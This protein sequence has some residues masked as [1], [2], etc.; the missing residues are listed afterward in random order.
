MRTLRFF[1]Y[2]TCLV[3]IIWSGVIL[4]GPS[5]VTWAIKSYTGGRVIV[6]NVSVTPK[7]DL[8]IGRL[9]FDLKKS[10]N[11]QPLRV[12]SRSLNLSWSLFDE[13]PA[14]KLTIGPTFSENVFKLDGATVSIPSLFGISFSAIPFIIEGSNIEFEGFTSAER[15]SL[16]GLINTETNYLSEL[17]IQA[18]DVSS[19]NTFLFSASA[20]TLTSDEIN[21]SAP[22]TGANT[23]LDFFATDL[24]ST[25]PQ[26]RALDASGSIE[27]TK[28]NLRVEALLSEV[29]VPSYNSMLSG[30]AL[31]F[32]F[33]LNESLV[34]F[35]L[36]FSKGILYNSSATIE[37]FSLEF[38]GRQKNQYNLIASGALDQVDL[39]YSSN[40]FGTLP[41][42]TFQ[43]DV[44]IDN[45][46]SVIKGETY[47]SLK[48]LSTS[49]IDGL[50]KI[51]LSAANSSGVLACFLEA[52]DFM[53]GIVSYHLNID[54]E[55]VK[56]TISC[57]EGY[58]GETTAFSVSTSNTGAIFDSLNKSKILNPFV[59]AQLYSAIISG[60]KV[61]VGHSLKVISD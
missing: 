51:E 14:I 24:K 25:N 20:V 21:F 34:N 54:E 53:K 11:F 3:S 8:T 9:N 39:I 13:E 4:A 15:F 33:D 31:D 16:S 5:I 28:V 26:T 59:T 23:S 37:E 18:H 57:L 10:E 36:D 2:C 61:G 60:E 32:N 43:L 49:K 44:D 41:P 55:W 17:F 19:K 48:D 52:C 42:S 7:L 12:F 50:A 30:A 40:Y 1:L 38:T 58:C 46:N 56:G 29:Q 22:T 47:M 6:S 35:R 27:L 45:L